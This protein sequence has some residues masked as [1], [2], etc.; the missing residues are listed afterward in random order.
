VLELTGNAVGDGI[1]GLV[2]PHGG[3]LVGGGGA[4]EGSWGL[5]SLSTLGLGDNGLGSEHWHALVALVGEVGSTLAQLDLSRNHLHA[6]CLAWILHVLAAP[7][8]HAHAGA[9]DAPDGARPP[10]PSII[11]PALSINVGMAVG[12]VGGFDATAV[13]ELPVQNMLPLLAARHVRALHLGGW[14][15]QGEA[16]AALCRALSQ[17]CSLQVLEIDVSAWEDWRC[18]AG[19]LKALAQRTAAASPACRRL[20]VAAPAP[21]AGTT[22]PQP[23]VAADVGRGAHEHA[24]TAGGLNTLT[25]RLTAPRR[26]TTSR[27][28]PPSPGHARPSSS[29]GAGAEGLVACPPPLAELLWA[30]SRHLVSSPWLHHVDLSNCRLADAGAACLARA[31]CSAAAAASCPSRLRSLALACNSLGVAGASALSRAIKVL[32]VTSCPDVPSCPVHARVVG[33]WRQAPRLLQLLTRGRVCVSA[34]GAA[35]GA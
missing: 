12:R 1:Q 8:G 22:M 18:V 9:L 3:A 6:D 31:L 27:P 21:P 26:R 14:R 19:L 23:L 2:A 24:S 25:L 17:S 10:A 11:P 5:A 29:V 28:P 34:T 4:G 30:L 20:A 35:L 32:E 33:W 13:P 7:R 15:C 16:L